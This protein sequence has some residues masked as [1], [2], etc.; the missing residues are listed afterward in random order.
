MKAVMKILAWICVALCLAGCGREAAHP[1][2][3]VVRIP[4]DPTESVPETTAETEVPVETVPETEIPEA[5]EKPDSG[6]AKP[7]GG[8]GSSSSGNKKPS[9]SKATE[10]PATEPPVTEPPATE[11]PATEPPA[12]EPPETQPP[13]DPSA[14]SVGSL[15]YAILDQINAYRREEGLAELSISTKLCG[16]A[17]LRATEVAELWSHNR[18]DGRSYTTAMSDYGYSFSLSAENLAFAAGS[19]DA[20]AI[21]AE[22]MEAAT[23]DNILG[24]GFTTAGIGVFR[25]GGGIYVVNILVG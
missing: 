9:G 4:V 11:P 8:K 13:Y 15:E 12:T 24:S 25:S 5:T 10:P 23:R 17:G 1:V 18:P 2:D 19:G 14:Y 16:I 6:S 3:T 22:W 21:V 7:S 20:A